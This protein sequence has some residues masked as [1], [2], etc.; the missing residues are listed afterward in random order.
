MKQIQEQEYWAT[1]CRFASVLVFLLTWTGCSKSIS[2][3]NDQPLSN[4]AHS[5][6]TLKFSSTSGFGNGSVEINAWDGWDHPVTVRIQIGTRPLQEKSYPPHHPIARK[7]RTIVDTQVFNL[8]GE[9][10][11][12]PTP[13]KDLPRIQIEYERDGTSK[14]VRRNYQ[15]GKRF[16]PRW[17]RAESL[18]EEII[19]LSQ[20]Q[21]D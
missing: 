8:P 5:P 13:G 21:T 15:W 18:F 2:T 16:E 6:F 14:I 12:R 4:I 20:L 11:K 7:A 19:S 1:L 3:K 9:Y 17:H 10:Y